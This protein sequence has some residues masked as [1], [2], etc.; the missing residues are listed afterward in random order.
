MDGSAATNHETPGSAPRA[1]NQVTALQI[2]TTL[3]WEWGVPG[4]SG[5]TRGI[6]RS[7]YRL[8]GGPPHWDPL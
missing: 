1:L 2:G 7:S 6:G 8:E 4:S 3:L 5:V